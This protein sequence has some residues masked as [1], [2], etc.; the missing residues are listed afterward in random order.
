MVVLV[1]AGL[2][3]GS[4][5]CGYLWVSLIKQSSHHGGL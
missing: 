2:V 5:L 3:A 1:T 4:I